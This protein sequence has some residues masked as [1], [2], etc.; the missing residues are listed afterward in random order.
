MEGNVVYFGLYEMRVK[1]WWCVIEEVLLHQHHPHLV[2][3]EV[4]RRPVFLFLQQQ[5]CGVDIDG[6]HVY[7]GVRLL[8]HCVRL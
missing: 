2:Q 5:S 7:G 8:Q 1:E 3:G 4:Q 6:V